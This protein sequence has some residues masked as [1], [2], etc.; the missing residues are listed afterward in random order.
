MKAALGLRAVFFFAVFLAAMEF[1]YG[2][3]CGEHKS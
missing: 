2:T 1:V 3:T